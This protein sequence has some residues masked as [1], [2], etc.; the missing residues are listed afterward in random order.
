MNNAV[1]V[2]I[3]GVSGYAGM[4]LARILAAHPRFAVALAV[5]DKWAGRA[6]GDCLPVGGSAAAVNV[7]AQAEGAKQ[8]GLGAI[9]L[10]F[11]CTPPEVS[12]ALAPLALDAG[13]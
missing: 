7:T 3:V 11:L 1:R 9:E 10:I 8:P 12:L 2:G 6:L 13:A 5:S 4:E